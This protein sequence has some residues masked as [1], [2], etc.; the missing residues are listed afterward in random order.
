MD[1]S[2]ATTTAISN[3]DRETIRVTLDLQCSDL[4]LGSPPEYIVRAAE[5][6]YQANGYIPHFTQL[7]N[8][9][10][11]APPTESNTSTATSDN[12]G[13]DETYDITLILENSQRN[14]NTAEENA[15]IIGQNIGTLIQ[16]FQQSI[17]NRT[18]VSTEQSNGE[19]ATEP[20]PTIEQSNDLQ[21]TQNPPEEEE[22]EDDNEEE[23][24][25]D[26]DEDNEEDNGATLTGDINLIDSIQQFTNRIN[27]SRAQPMRIMSIPGLN[28]Q[29]TFLAIGNNDMGSLGQIL[30]NYVTLEQPMRD[31]V[32]VV[33][34]INEI[35]LIFIKD[36]Q[37]ID[38]NMSS[39]CLLCYDQFFPT[40][41]VRV[42]PCNH[43]F[44]RLC[45]DKLLTTVSHL[46]PFC[47]HPAGE[48]KF[49]E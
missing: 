17:L 8:T 30:S 25:D 5:Q 19:N 42:L 14:T 39:G 9:P 38:E 41:L 37:T 34:D 13:E 21:A 49:I 2:I 4:G 27:S 10:R 26:D 33:K 46:C 40:D 1:P 24:D 47:K 44:H 12:N 35:K 29:N 6:F 22:G 11:T 15:A 36:E 48:H 3:D 18:V 43:C 23:E 20:S 31:V 16:A 28:A 7:I 45:V 32:K